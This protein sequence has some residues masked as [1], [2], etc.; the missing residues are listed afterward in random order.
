M[1]FWGWEPK[2][3]RHQGRTELCRHLRFGGAN[4]VTIEV[5]A[6]GQPI[7]TIEWKR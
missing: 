7:K 5:I 4:T 1:P 3:N 2:Y 6:P